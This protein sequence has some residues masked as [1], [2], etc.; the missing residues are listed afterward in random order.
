M[1]KF[2]GEF[3]VSHPLHDTFLTDDF[4]EGVLAK[5]E[6]PRVLPRLKECTKDSLVEI[7]KVDVRKFELLFAQW[8]GE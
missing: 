2:Q 1:K 6:K 8:Q 3:E 7:S 4:W 5:S